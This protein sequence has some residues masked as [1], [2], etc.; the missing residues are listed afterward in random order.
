MTKANETKEA[1]EAWRDNEIER[2]H[3]ELTRLGY[4][5]KNDQPHIS[6]ERFLMSGRK[7]VL[8][9]KRMNDNKEAIVKYSTDHEGRAEIQDERRRRDGLEHIHFAYHQ[10]RFPDELLWED[11]AGHSLLITEFIPQRTIFIEL[12]LEEQFF[13]ALSA[14]ESQEGVHVAVSNHEREI[15]ALAG[16]MRADDYLRE[17]DGWRERIRALLPDSTE[18][19]ETLFYASTFLREHRTTIERYS[20]FLTHTDFVPHN[21]RVSDGRITILDHTSLI[22][23]NK[24]ESWARFI[25]FMTL[26]NPKLEELLVRYVRENRGADEYLCLRAMRAYKIGFLLDYRV[27]SLMQADGNLRELTKERIVVWKEALEAV[28]EDKQL[29]EEALAHY[30]KSAIALR[31]PEE[32]V[33]QQEISGWK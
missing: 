28:L 27:T 20:G 5:L 1:W 12:P 9:A 10:M 21:L 24:Y 15:E 16:S 13:L 30:K 23:G 4:T 3:S 19:N 14:L 26:Y 18:L 6:G 29:S 33:R 11:H 8:L 2:A 7:L 22:I 17:F 25:N 31:S 32:T